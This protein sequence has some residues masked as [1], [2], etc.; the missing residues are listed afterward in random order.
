[1]TRQRPPC[2]PPA[3]AA[4]EIDKACSAADGLAAGGAAAPAALRA[5]AQ[6]RSGAVLVALAKLRAVAASVYRMSCQSIAGAGDVNSWALE[7]QH[8][9]KDLLEMAAARDPARQA[10]IASRVHRTYLVFRA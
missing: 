6:H 10:R 7:W 8:L 4:Q 2:D 9:E 5:A 1:M 3:P